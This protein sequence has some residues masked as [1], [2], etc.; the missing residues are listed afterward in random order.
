MYKITK[1]NYCD[2]ILMMFPIYIEG[3][4]RNLPNIRYTIYYIIMQVIMRYGQLDYILGLT[5]LD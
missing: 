1:V 2:R 4:Y 3:Q 5:C